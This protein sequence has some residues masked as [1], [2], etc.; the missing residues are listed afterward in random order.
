RKILKVIRDSVQ[1]RGHLPSMREIGETVGL[2]STSSVAFQLSTL[3]R[4]GYLHHRPA[5]TEVRLPGNPATQPEPDREE[6]ETAEKPGID[7]PSQETACVP[8][9]GRIAAGVP[10]LDEQCVK[11]VLPLPRQLVGEGTLFMLKVKDDAL[12]GAA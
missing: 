10:I 5:T 2:A 9:I 8:L 3:Q 11:D 6:G 7:I 12:I 1:E 4:K